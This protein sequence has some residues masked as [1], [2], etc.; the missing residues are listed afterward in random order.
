MPYRAPPTSATTPTSR[1]FTRATSRPVRSRSATEPT[2]TQPLANGREIQARAVELGRVL[3][4]D[5]GPPLVGQAIEHEP[6]VVEVPVRIVGREA[7]IV[8]RSSR[9]EHLEK[10]LVAPVRVLERLGR[11]ANV[12]SR[13]L[14]RLALEPWH[15]APQRAPV[16]VQAPENAR[17][18]G[19][20]AL[21]QK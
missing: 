17:Q 2:S 15:L 8:G 14:A 18:P 3:V 11:E 4:Q 21:E 5:L 19:D 9:L 16:R 7:E 6:G 1:P 12:L 13:D 10:R 20:T